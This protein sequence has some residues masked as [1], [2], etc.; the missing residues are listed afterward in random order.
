MPQAHFKDFKGLAPRVRGATQFGKVVSNVDLYGNTIRP[1]PKDDFVSDPKRPGKFVRISGNIHHIPDAAEIKLMTFKGYYVVLY[2]KEGGLK[3]YKKVFEDADGAGSLTTPM[4]FSPPS[5]PAESVYKETND[6]GTIEFNRGFRPHVYKAN[7]T[8]LPP[9]TYSY[10]IEIVNIKNGKEF[11]LK[12]S[13]IFKQLVE[14]KWFR[15][16]T[17]IEYNTQ[18]ELDGNELGRTRLI[19]ADSS[20]KGFY[21]AYGYTGWSGELNTSWGV[22]VPATASTTITTRANGGRTNR[23]T[24]V[25]TD[26]TIPSTLSRINKWFYPT[27]YGHGIDYSAL[28]TDAQAYTTDNN[29]PNFTGGNARSKAIFP[30]MGKPL[31]PE[32]II[33]EGVEVNTDIGGIDLIQNNTT[34]IS[35]Y[36]LDGTDYEAGPYLFQNVTVEDPSSSVADTVG[37]RFEL[38][39]KQEDTSELEG[40]VRYRLYR[41]SSFDTGFYKVCEVAHEYSP[42]DKFLVLTDT[43]KP[44]TEYKAS[45]ERTYRYFTTYNRIAGISNSGRLATWEEESGPSE[46]QSI[47]TYSPSIFI[48]RPVSTNLDMTGVDTWNLY[49]IT[50]GENGTSEFQLAAST[51]I[52]VEEVYDDVEDE[53]LGEAPNSAFLNETIPY[54]Y[55]AMPDGLTNLSEFYNGMLFGWKGGSLYWTD[56]FYLS[57]W[58]TDFNAELPYNIV[59]VIPMGNVMAIVTTHGVYRAMASNPFDFSFVESP[60]GEGGKI[61]LPE[62][63]IASDKG[64]IFLSDSG[65]QLYDGIRSSSMTDGLIGEEYFRTD[66]DL[67]NAILREN[68]GLLFLFHGTG[69]LVIDGRSQ[70]VSTI[71]DLVVTQVFRD[72]EEG[73][74]F[75]MDVQ[76]RIAQ[77]FSSRERK[78]SQTY[79]TGEVHFGANGRKRVKYIQF[80]G[81]GKIQCTPYINGQSIGLKAKMI[82][83]DGMEADTRIYLPMS[84]TLDSL[85]IELVGTGEVEEFL[86]DWERM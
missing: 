74:L 75:Y 29:D 46:E 8:P 59:N 79:R 43:N 70:Q 61:G 10:F 81:S 76:N 14:Y 24:T 39:V 30:T 26:P 73:S 78:R 5:F 32:S 82:N 60:S 44:D 45:T 21:L 20:D 50:E 25:V 13:D 35:G 58:S 37:V 16:P 18:V 3:W 52:D 64:V 69:C 15:D 84:K 11:V 77:L 33:D 9:D 85:E 66:I 31:P 80:L 40:D 83:M 12:R 34:V 7:E 68:D 56:R 42:I 54:V 19:R 6:L 65:L 57:G 47:V 36:I 4:S 22:D 71:S 67:T 2:R 38:T 55:E 72:H 86:I 62:T 41:S 53:A 51:S 27:T 1:F 63:V 49:R 17:S 23:T 28:S 48:K